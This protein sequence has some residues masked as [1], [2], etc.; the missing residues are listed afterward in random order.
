MVAHYTLKY[1][2]KSEENYLIMIDNM[3]HMKYIKQIGEKCMKFWKKEYFSK[4]KFMKYGQKPRA[5]SNS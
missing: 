4:I 3:I 5:D 2:L 1:L